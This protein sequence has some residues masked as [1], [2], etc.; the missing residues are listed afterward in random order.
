[1]KGPMLLST[2]I[3]P[4]APPRDYML[5]FSSLHLR[6]I[7]LPEEIIVEDL[8]TKQSESETDSSQFG[9]APANFV[10]NPISVLAVDS[11][12]VQRLNLAER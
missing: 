6:D 5:G 8:N 12:R 10:F 7:Y 2:M 9:P 4:D 11:G 1:M 3:F